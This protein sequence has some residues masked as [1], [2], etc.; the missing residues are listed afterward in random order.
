MFFRLC[1][2]L[3]NLTEEE[4]NMNG[5]KTMIKSILYSYYALA[6]FDE[7]FSITVA[8]NAFSKLIGVVHIQK[9]K[10]EETSILYSSPT[11]SESESNNSTDYFEALAIIFSHDKFH[12]YI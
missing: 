11:L 7:G 6:H 3:Y 9:N 5:I 2:Q 10:G 1:K 4:I 8:I 12:Q